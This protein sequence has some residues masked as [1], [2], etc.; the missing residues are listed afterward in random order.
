MNSNSEVDFDVVIAV[1][2]VNFAQSCAMEFDISGCVDESRKRGYYDNVRNNLSEFQQNPEYLAEAT[3]CCRRAGKVAR[4]MA[5]DEG[6]SIIS[7]EIFVAA[8][9]KVEG[10]IAK[11]RLRIATRSQTDFHVLGGVC[12]A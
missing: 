6:D 12:S 9:A 2:W 4:K 1:F 5:R 7:R 11:V 3:R 10:K 8:V